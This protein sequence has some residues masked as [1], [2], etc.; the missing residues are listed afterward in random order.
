MPKL[1]SKIDLA[2]W[3]AVA[4]LLVVGFL[5]VKKWHDDAVFYRAKTEQLLAVKKVEKQQD[6]ITEGV[7]H[8]IRQG[9]AAIN[10]PERSLAPVSVCKPARLRPV[11]EPASGA[12]GTPAD[13]QS[14]VS[15]GDTGRDVTFGLTVYGKRCEVVRLRASSWQTWW[16]EQNELSREVSGE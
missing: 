15:A 2:I 14:G 4:L 10:A 9:E 16:R 13:S 5:V 8:E 7:G 11:P 6:K 3:G 12:A 1:P